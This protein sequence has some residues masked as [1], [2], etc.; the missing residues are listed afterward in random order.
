L[1]LRNPALLLRFD[2]QQTE[3]KSMDTNSKKFTGK[4]AFVTGGSRG[5]LTI[6]GGFAA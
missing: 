4:V 3:G 6:D 2:G 1:W 5:R